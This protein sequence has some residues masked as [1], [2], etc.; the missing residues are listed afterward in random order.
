MAVPGRLQLAGFEVTPEALPPTG[1]SGIWQIGAAAKMG[2]APGTWTAPPF[3]GC[4][5]DILY[6]R[7]LL[8][9]REVLG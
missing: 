3:T 7:L 1:D 6:S 4:Y 8:K 9:Y 5:S 2:R